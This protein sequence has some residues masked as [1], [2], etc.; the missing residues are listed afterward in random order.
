MVRHTACVTLI[1]RPT[2]VEVPLTGLSFVFPTFSSSGLAEAAD[3]VGLKRTATPR[4]QQQLVDDDMFDR[5]CFTR[6]DKQLLGT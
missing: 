2:V 5:I 3:G 4:F 6:S 1:G